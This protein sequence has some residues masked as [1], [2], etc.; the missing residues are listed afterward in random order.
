MATN[1]ATGI[2]DVQLMGLPDVKRQLDGIPRL[3]DGVAQSA[4]NIQR[5]MV[6]VAT[7]ANKNFAAF[8]KKYSGW[9]TAQLQKAGVQVPM[10]GA[11][12]VQAEFRK[13]MRER[14]KVGYEA[15]TGKTT[16]D[17]LDAE[18]RILLQLK[19]QD[20]AAG[21]MNAA[22]ERV[23]E[24]ELKRVNLS[25]QTVHREA[26]AFKGILGQEFGVFQDQATQRK[27]T[28]DLK[29]MKEG[30]DEFRKSREAGTKVGKAFAAQMEAQIATNEKFIAQK[31]KIASRMTIVGRARDELRAK[32]SSGIALT[33]HEERE[34]KSLNRE[35][36]GLRQ[37]LGAVAAKQNAFNTELHEFGTTSRAANF[38]MQQ[39][40]FAGQD[41]IQV[42]GQTGFAGALHASANNLSMFVQTL[43]IASPK[44]LAFGAFG[45]TAGMMA[46]SAWL[47]ATKKEAKSLADELGNLADRVDERFKRSQMLTEASGGGGSGLAR[48]MIES[49]RDVQLSGEKRSTEISRL[50]GDSV[51]NPGL[52]RSYG[53]DFRDIFSLS[54]MDSAF[55]EE[56][57]LAKARGRKVRGEDTEQELQ[58]YLDLYARAA[59]VDKL[60]ESFE[61]HLR[62]KFDELVGTDRIEAAT[63]IFEELGHSGADLDAEIKQF[64]DVLEA[65]RKAKADFAQLEELAA[66]N[67]GDIANLPFA[68]AGQN[69]LMAIDQLS[70]TQFINDKAQNLAFSDAILGF[71]APGMTDVE[72]ATQDYS[73]AI[74][75]LT[76]EYQKI[77]EYLKSLQQQGKVDD[78]AIAHAKRQYKESL[79]GLAQ[80]QQDQAKKRD[81]FGLDAM[82]FVTPEGVSEIDR[83]EAKYANEAD[84]LI[85]RMRELYPNAPAQDLADDEQK[86]RDA[87][88]KREADA[89]AD[90]TRELKNSV[91][92]ETNWNN[93]FASQRSSLL[94]SHKKKADEIRQSGL[95]SE[96]QQRLLDQL[97][98]SGKQQMTSLDMQED[99]ARFGSQFAGRFGG[100]SDLQ[101]QEL[102]IEKQLMDALIAIQGDPYLTGAEKAGRAE[103][104]KESAKE[105]KFAARE[106]FNKIGLSDPKSLHKQIQMSLKKP[107]SEKLAE[108]QLKELQT[109][110]EINQDLLDAISALGIGT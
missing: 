59:K 58:Q 90:Y 12:A 66:R 92:E 1:I 6:K 69:L 74:A 107:K 9:S 88:K 98:R 14:V 93:R 73:G 103:I 64:K 2:I 17:I 106:N 4:I 8:Q 48:R 33:R 20:Q 94:E 71:S 78:R 62:E 109:A 97:F 53:Q 56:S 11:E 29:K 52:M 34:L 41:M 104:A 32:Q 99:K 30:L 91:A 25:R 86:I 75:R 35:I 43:D 85:D 13:S 16:L 24:T 22:L 45:V 82:S 60:T 21:K 68:T 77:E 46:L 18:E 40:S 3:L 42:W 31:E 76:R 96:Q 10:T 108:D 95:G 37:K 5:Q 87:A 110:N 36:T 7:D 101:S 28:E 23:Y 79:K 70:Q 102:A 84:A 65:E 50:A 49:G 19:A 80:S 83:I 39:L 105:A 57:I 81:A 54:G 89:I 51:H 27:E 61:K 100:E 67:V 63:K 47:T 26:S 15:E 72:K 55:T 44:L 38:R